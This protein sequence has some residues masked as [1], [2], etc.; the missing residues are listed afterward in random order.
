MKMKKLFPVLIFLPVLASCSLTPFGNE[1]PE[2]PIPGEP[3]VITEE[4]TL[5]N[6]EGEKYVFETNEI[7]YLTESGYTIW[8]TRHLNESDA[9]EPISVRMC[10]DTGR[11]EAGYGI[12]FC[13]QEIKGRPFLLT[14]LINNNGMYA[15]G[16]V[17]DGVYSHLNKEWKSSSY[18]NRG[19]GV[20]NKI[21]VSYDD[22]EK[23]FQLKI[24]G[25]DITT[26]TIQE[27]IKFKDSRWGYVAVIAANEDFP[28]NPV[29]V[30]FEKAGQ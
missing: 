10:K 26:F 16:K 6:E 23:N 13:S 25:H 9:F 27:N 24:N 2:E 14:V 21:D 30:T 1:T 20:W 7:A 12:V 8:T 17:T 28:N 22:S 15:V 4:S 11:A 18:I 5:Y 29:K 19:W 3:S